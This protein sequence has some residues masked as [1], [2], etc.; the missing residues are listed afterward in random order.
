MC[1]ADPEGS[2]SPG[3]WVQASLTLWAGGQRLWGKASPEWSPGGI[4]WLLQVL[5]APRLP[6][7]TWR[8]SAVN[9]YELQSWWHLSC[10]ALAPR[11]G[12]A[13]TVLARRVSCWT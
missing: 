7:P 4:F 1:W 8:S 12:L 11:S 9:G 6:R 2:L 5:L 10:L 3:Q 13:G